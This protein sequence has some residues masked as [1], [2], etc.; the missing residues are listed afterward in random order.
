MTICTKDRELNSIGKSNRKGLACGRYAFG[1]GS[2][3]CPHAKPQQN[4]RFYFVL[5]PKK[6]LN[7]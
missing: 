5:V 1:D 7:I 4:Y 2:G 6:H 3:F